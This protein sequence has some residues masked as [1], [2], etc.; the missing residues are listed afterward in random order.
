MT[1]GLHIRWWSGARA[2]EWHFTFRA[3]LGR[4][5][6]DQGAAGPHVAISVDL[7]QSDPDAVA[8]PVSRPM[9]HASVVRSSCMRHSEW[10]VGY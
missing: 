6:A 1:Y 5:F 7:E 10:G 3:N 2:V 4:Q 9:S 8:S